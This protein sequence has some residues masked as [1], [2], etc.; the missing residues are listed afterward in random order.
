MA[1]RKDI[2][3]CGHE[4]DQH[5]N[6]IIKPYHPELKYNCCMAGDHICGCSG[7]KLKQKK[8]LGG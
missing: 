5:N 8:S 6:R 1:H 7:F 4:R 2:C 3:G